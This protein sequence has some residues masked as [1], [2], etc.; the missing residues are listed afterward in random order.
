M[1]FVTRKG[2][3]ILFSGSSFF[4]MS[5]EELYMCVCAHVRALNYLMS[6]LLVLGGVYYTDTNTNLFACVSV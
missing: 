1:R 5:T 4:I 2:G 6:S 3:L